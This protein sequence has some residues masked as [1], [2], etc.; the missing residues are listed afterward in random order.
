MIYVLESATMNGLDLVVVIAIIAAVFGLWPR[1][2]KVNRS[3][4]RKNL[5]IVSNY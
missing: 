4:R 2:A 3:T 5:R 1:P